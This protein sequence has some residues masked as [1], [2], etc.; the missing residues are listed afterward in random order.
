MMHCTS[1]EEKIH[2]ATY[3]AHYLLSIEAHRS[4]LLKCFKHVTSATRKTHTHATQIEKQI[5]SPFESF[6]NP[7]SDSNDAHACGS[8]PYKLSASVSM[9]QFT[10]EIYSTHLKKSGAEFLLTKKPLNI[11]NTI[12]KGIAT[13]CAACAFLAMAATIAHIESIAKKRIV[14]HR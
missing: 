12:R 7:K 13:A 1:D 2:L 5:H 6:S 14:A 10:G 4:I 9:T 11:M 3:F 8:S